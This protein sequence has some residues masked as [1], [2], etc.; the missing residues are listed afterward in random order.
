V[1]EQGLLANAVIYLRVSTKEQAQKGG[2]VEGYSIPA[3][4][5]ACT[6]KA[7]SMGARVAA[8]FVDAGESAKTSA[9]PQ[10][11]AMLSRLSEG[12][13][14][15][16]IVH[17]VDRL[18]R[19][20]ADDVTISLAITTAGARL[21]SVSEN[22][23]ETPSGSLLHGIMSSVAEFYSKNLANE[24]MKGMTQKA[25][26]GGT[27]GLAPIGYINLSRT[28]NHRRMSEIEI[29]E[30]RAPLVQWA[31]RT[32]ATG[33]YSLNA[34]TMMLEAQGLVTIQREKT[35][36]KPLSHSQVHR[37]LQNKYY[38]G[39]VVFNGAEHDG[40]HTPLVSRK[41]FQRVQDI[42]HGHRVAGDRQRTHN[43]YLRGS[44][45]CSLCGKRLCFTRSIKSSG[46]IYDY[47]F[48][49]GKQKNHD[50]NFQNLKV[51]QIEWHVTN[52]WKHIKFEPIYEEIIKQAILE[53][54]HDTYRENEALQKAAEKKRAEV[55]DKQER[56]LEA[57]YAGAISIDVLKRQQDHLARE[58]ET[59]EQTLKDNA[60]IVANVE[61]NLDKCLELIKNWHRSYRLSKPHG[62]RLM[63]QAMFEKITVEENGITPV[64]N[65]AFGLLFATD[66]LQPIEKPVEYHREKKEERSALPSYVYDKSA[67][68]NG[69]PAWL[70]TG[71]WWTEVKKTT[72]ANG[73]S[74]IKASLE[75]A[76]LSL[77]IVALVRV[78]GL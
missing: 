19:N 20:R 37:M 40:T 3:Q 70:V 8:E 7:E 75:K 16:V 56:V 65:E 77:N 58:H 5:A 21:V 67:W 25:R 23:D 18:A 38:I 54:L 78:M 32:Y 74:T 36:G 48:C 69:V 49:V 35:G 62:R 15:Y 30:S 1:S 76:G 13:I 42:L 34:L 9:R 2:E 33:Q 41:T 61:S 12:G 39:T 27:P 66:I 11:Q 47:Y 55:M 51:R 29:D 28:I 57:Y 52:E 6:R 63:N 71:G 17:K 53:E 31:F 22:I 43:H 26:N 14:Q 45:L 68:I 10:L 4:R 50:C 64:M 73:G 24:V 60:L 72:L 59:V 44:L 46:L